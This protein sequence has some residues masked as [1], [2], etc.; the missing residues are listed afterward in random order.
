MKPL[1]RF[2]YAVVRRLRIID[3]TQFLHLPQGNTLSVACPHEFTVRTVN[4]NELA[5]LT[6]SN[7][8]DPMVGDASRLRHP[9]RALI[10]VFSGEQ[11]VSFLW[12]ANEAVDSRDNYSRSEHLGTSINMPDGTVFIYNAWTSPEHRGKRLIAAMVSWGLHNR[13]LGAHA[14][15]T[16]ID[17]TNDRSIR[18]FEHLGMQRLGWTTR[19]GCGRFQFSIVPSKAKRF[20]LKIADSAPGVKLAW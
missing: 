2:L 1:F 14:C 9:R 7:L 10:A 3:V 13:V 5:T 4:E 12:L 6:K 15:L 20:G 19:I 11:V 17:C 16:M 18:A 8:I